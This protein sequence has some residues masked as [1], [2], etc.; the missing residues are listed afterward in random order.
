MLQQVFIDRHTKK[1]GIVVAY[2]ENNLHVLAVNLL[3]TRGFLGNGRVYLIN[4]HQPDLFY[5]AY[6]VLQDSCY[7]QTFLSSLIRTKT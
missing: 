4:Q 6:A 3:V 1:L 5:Y 2:S 7:Q